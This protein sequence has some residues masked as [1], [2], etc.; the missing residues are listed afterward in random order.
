MEIPSICIICERQ[1]QLNMC[2]APDDGTHWTTSGNYGSTVYDE[3][4][5]T[6]Y[7]MTCICDECLKKKKDL[8]SRVK[9]KTATH[10]EYGPFG[11]N[12]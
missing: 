11:D 1:L 5:G 8:V 9:I 4:G 12:L 10:N 6:E 2:D 7:L 3:M